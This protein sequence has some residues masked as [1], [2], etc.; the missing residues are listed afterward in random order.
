VGTGPRV[1]KSADLARVGAPASR[2]A[3]ACPYPRP[4]P[5][6]FDDCSAY[7]G[8]LFVG[9]DLQYRP[10]PPTRTCRFLTV[11]EL[12]EPAGTF[13]GRCALGDA[14]ARLAFVG[15]LDRARLAKLR[16]L[17]LQLA[18]FSR[19]YVKELW[20]LKGDQLRTQNL[21][22]GAGGEAGDL[23]RALHSVRGR[24][25]REIERFLEEH[26]EGL[27]ELGL[28]PDAVLQ[29]A[30]ITL[31]TFMRQ[32]T[33][34]QAPVELPDEVLERFPSD[35]RELLRPVSSLPQRTT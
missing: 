4:F 21:A 22:P 28:P 8:R 32:Q 1:S 35:V 15:R 2:R 19:P 23:D 34:A 24:F 31:E 14:E 29:A 27:R 30:S 3:D 13:Y 16:A 25:L 9:L 7:Q 5:E 26:D 33:T 18:S 12:T 17:Q 20:R 11:G 6:D 10:L